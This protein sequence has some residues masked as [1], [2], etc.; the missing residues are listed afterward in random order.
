MLPPYLIEVVPRRLLFRGSPAHRKI[1]RPRS[2][3]FSIGHH[4]F[5][6]VFDVVASESNPHHGI[7]HG[8][9]LGKGFHIRRYGVA[10]QLHLGMI[11]SRIVRLV[12]WLQR[13]PKL[14]S[15]C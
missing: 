13:K 10:P 14:Y 12:L 3:A 5:S 2:D 7:A 8:P 6:R 4:N 11:H 15:C 9:G 1:V